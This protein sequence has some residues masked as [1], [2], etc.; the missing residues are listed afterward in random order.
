MPWNIKLKLHSRNQNPSLAKIAIIV[1][2]I[3]LCLCLAKYIHSVFVGNLGVNVEPN[4]TWTNL[5]QTRRLPHLPSPSPMLLS[6][7]LSRHLLKSKRDRNIK[8]LC[9]VSR[10]VENGLVSIYGISARNVGFSAV[11]AGY[12]G[13]SLR[14]LVLYCKYDY[15]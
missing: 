7:V 3:G 13:R 10:R 11:T 12:V 1:G 6:L 8:Y 5:G 15:G 4:P 9:S 14:K 2:L